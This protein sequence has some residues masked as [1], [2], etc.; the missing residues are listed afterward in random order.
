KVFQAFKDYGLIVADNGADMYIQ[1]TYD[2]RWNDPPDPLDNVMI[3]AFNSLTAGDFEVIE[4]GY[5]P[6][7]AALSI[8]D[9]A[10]VAEGNSGTP[11]SANFVVALAPA[12]ATPVTV[13]YATSDGTAI[14]GADYVAK[15]GTLSFAA[16]ET[17][18]TITVQVKGD[19]LDEDDE[20]FAV[21]LSNVVGD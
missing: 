19:V 21:T 10:P 8:A 9:S 13:D 18:K 7:V 5:N 1:G 11:N 3:D 4:L 12:S 2:T 6:P 14:A 17:S 16:G 15:T 20:T